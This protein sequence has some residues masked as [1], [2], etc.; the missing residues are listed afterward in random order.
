MSKEMTRRKFIKTSAAIGGGVALSGTLMPKIVIGT[1]AADMGIAKGKDYVKNTKKAV[2]IIGGMEKFVAE[3]SRVAILANPQ[4]NNPGVFTKP[5]VLRGAIHMCK[6]AGAKSIGCISWLPQENW[7]S[8]GLKK[9]VD[10]EDVQLLIT[11]LR[12]ESLFKSTK[13]PKGVS[14]KE[15]RIMNSYFECDVFINIAI[16]KEHSGNNYTGALKNLMGLSSPKTNGKFHKKNWKTDKDSIAH[17]E[18]CIADLNT[19]IKPDL[20]IIDAT[21]IIITNGPFGPGEILKPLKVLAGTDPVALDTYC[22]QLWGLQPADIAAINKAYEH[23]LGEMDLK[24]LTIKE[25]EI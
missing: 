4:R 11:N 5:E 6:D 3:N 7:E 19:I 20:C 9:V 22:C 18:Q 23:G 17:M 16:S 24:K 10:E 15:A 2:E 8:T 12:D 1:E 13:V 21:E 14:L 25:V